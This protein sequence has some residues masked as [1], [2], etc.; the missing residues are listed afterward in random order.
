MPGSFPLIDA[1]QEL[2]RRDF[3]LGIDEY[4]LALR[5]LAVGFGEE[6]REDLLLLCRSL[7]AQSIEESEQVVD[8]LNAVLPPCVSQEMIEGLERAAREADKPG[9]DRPAGEDDA[10]ALQPIDTQR[11][12]TTGTAD[13]E[14]SLG[15]EMGYVRPWM[16]FGPSGPDSES[17]LPDMR[18]APRTWQLDPR[19]DF[20]GTLPV[21]KRQISQAWRHYRQMSRVGQR[22]EFDVDATVTQLH[23]QG[24]LLEPVLIPRRTN[25]ARLLILEDS[26]GSMVPFRYVT[27]NLVRGAQHVGLARV[28][29]RYF[30]D[31]PRGVVFR[32]PDQLDPVSVEETAAPFSN[33]SIL[34]YSDAGAARGGMDDTRVSRTADL[35]A[36]L[37]RYTTA[38]AWLNPVPRRR[39]AGTTA[40]AICDLE[41]GVVPM[42][43]LDHPGLTAAIDV[44][45]GRGFDDR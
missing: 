34:L 31:V 22:I 16:G 42:F 27:R 12:Q 23:R 37:R 5:A 40:Q 32:D 19:F 26:G 39:W 43:P 15:D 18:P 21:T 24:V 36:T 20:L 11:E 38:I 8:V 13:E 6:S 9:P 7:W 33:A 45:R 2:R 25:Q 41:H 44:L 30:H 10:L 3:P 28:D 29:V 35:F 4:V 1:F 17:A 14:Q